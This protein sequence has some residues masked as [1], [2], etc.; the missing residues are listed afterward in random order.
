MEYVKF[1]VYHL[2]YLFCIAIC[3]YC[4]SSYAKCNQDMY[5]RIYKQVTLQCLEDLHNM[6]SQEAYARK[7]TAVTQLRRLCNGQ[8][9]T[10]ELKNPMNQLNQGRKK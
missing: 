9:S 7:Y 1:F 5:D 3:T 10:Y 6:P 8:L 4:V 2:W